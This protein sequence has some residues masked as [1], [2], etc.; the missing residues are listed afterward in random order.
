MMD[1]ISYTAGKSFNRTNTRNIIII[2]VTQESRLSGDVAY[3][4]REWT[5]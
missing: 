4:E 1:H 3:I 5:T 2:T